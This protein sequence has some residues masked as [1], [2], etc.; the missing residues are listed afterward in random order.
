MTDKQDISPNPFVLNISPL[1]STPVPIF[2]YLAASDLS[3]SIAAWQ[4][5]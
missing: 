2:T 1:L 4:D 5:L 3:G